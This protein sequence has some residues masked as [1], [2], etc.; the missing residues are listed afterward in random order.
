MRAEKWIVRML[1]IAVIF[2]AL[3][4]IAAAVRRTVVLFFPPTQAGRQN[5]AQELDANF[6]GHRALTLLHVVPGFLFMVLGPLQFVT[7]MRSRY[8]WFHRWSGRV[9]VASGAVIGFSA[10]AMSSK[11][12]IGGA[13][14]TAATTFFAVVFLFD[15]GKAFLH[16]RRRE[17]AQHREWMIRAFAI[18]LAIATIRPIVVT[19][20]AASRLSPHEFFGIAFWLGFTLHLILAEIWIHHTRGGLAAPAGT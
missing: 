10:L 1:W 19:F 7:R 14:E 13:N 8:L 3:I 12:A 17:I 16:V 15:L 5:P 11:M 6:A 2:L 18:G 20:F 9:L 4:G